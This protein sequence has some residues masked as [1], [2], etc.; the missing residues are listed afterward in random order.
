MTTYIGRVV[1]V[2]G[3]DGFGFVGIKSLTKSDGSDHDLETANDIFIH[4]DDC[5]ATLRVGLEVSF[6]AIPDKKRGEGYMRAMGAVESAQCELLPRHQPMPGFNALM[7]LGGMPNVSLEIRRLPVHSR[8]KAVPE[9]L[10]G[11]VIANK[12]APEIPRESIEVRDPETVLRRFLLHLYP[13]LELFGSDFN[14]LNADDTEFDQQVTEAIETQE[15]LGMIEQVEKTRQEISAFKKTRAT[16]SF[17]HENG[18]VRQ[19]AILPMKYLPDIFM[20]V[21]VWFFWITE[22]KKSETNVSWN[23]Q[24]PAVSAQA[25]YFCDQFPTQRWYDLF[26]MFNRRVRPLAQYKGDI[27]PPHVTRR[28]K[29]AT[30]LFDYVVIM[31]P[32][33]D[34]AGR[35]W[36]NLEWLR[37]ID[38]YLVGFKQGIPYFFI[39]GRFSDSGTFP[40][41]NELVADTIAFLKANQ[42]KLAGFNEVRLP[43]WYIGPTQ[44]EGGR[45]STW[46]SDANGENGSLGTHL[47]SFTRDLLAA[48]DRRVLFDWLRGGTD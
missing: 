26:Q 43:F 40:L 29:E 4:Q 24:D 15:G 19:D 31:T 17:L 36:Q 10:V 39:L 25:K 28:M 47:Q 8:M 46:R 14:V 1:S 16:F 41:H 2:P 48:F 18:L 45:R 7:P 27:I 30:V 12:P 33:T 37:S 5:S 38:P 21:P 9:E 32:Y 44:A 13:A 22:N 20:A 6:E 34:V 42:D 3:K 35:D 23:S 11:K